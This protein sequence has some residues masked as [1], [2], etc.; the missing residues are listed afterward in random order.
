M[1]ATSALASTRQIHG[2][3]RISLPATVA[4]NPE[5]LKSSIGELVER[6]GCPKCFSGADCVFSLDRDFLVDPA[7][8][9]EVSAKRLST[10]GW[11]PTPATP[12]E[13]STITVSLARGVRYDIKKIFQAIDNLIRHDIFG[14]LACHSGFDVQFLNEVKFVGINEQL[15]VQQYGG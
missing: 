13:L 8:K 14:C 15:D 1:T 9:L 10:D 7:G 12:P 5:R 11:K 3:V 6:L 4:Y 2:T